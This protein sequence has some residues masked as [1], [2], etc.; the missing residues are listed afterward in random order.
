MTTY[1]WF[2]CTVRSLKDGHP[3]LET[4]AYLLSDMKKRG[5]DS[6]SDSEKDNLKTRIQVVQDELSMFA[7]LLGETLKQ[8]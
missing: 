2:D 5:W 8:A 6:L 3:S 4:N 1:E 7:E